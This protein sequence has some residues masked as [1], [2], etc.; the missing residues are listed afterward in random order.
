MSIRDNHVFFQKKPFSK[1]SADVVIR[2]S[3]LYRQPVYEHTDDMAYRFKHRVEYGALRSVTFLVRILPHRAALALGAALA[4]VSFRLMGRRAAETRRRLR[5]V[6]GPDVP[7]TD[8]RRWARRAWRNLFFNMIEIAR[9]PSLSDAAMARLVDARQLQRCV[10][11]QREH[12]GFTIAVCHM[13]NWELAGFSAR[14]MN[15]PIFVMMRGQSNPLVTAYLDRIREAFGVGAI[16]RHKALGSIIKRI[17]A[18]EVFTILP[19]IRSKVKESAVPVPFLGGTAYL[20]G[21]AAMFAR[22]TG[23]PV[24]TAIV[25]RQGWTRHIITVQDP[26]QPDPALERDDDIRRMTAL[27]MARF[28]EAIR[29][30]PDQYFWFNKRW[31]LDDR[32]EPAKRSPS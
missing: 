4:A 30:Q 26:I 12:G 7:E 17:R 14:R 29:K 28:D 23:T 19:D 1:Q 20:M 5:E 13:G 25:T 15:L 2:T 8:I 3:R 18:G 21:G 32:F 16:E 24:F 10:D 6:F 31:I 9:A 27:M 22:H 11:Y